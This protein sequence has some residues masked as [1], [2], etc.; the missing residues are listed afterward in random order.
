MWTDSLREEAEPERGSVTAKL[1]LRLLGWR[2]VGQ[3]PE[4]PKFLLIGAPH[5]SLSDYPLTALLLL[6][7]RLKPSWLARKV[8]FSW[9]LRPLA[10]AL[11]AMPPD[12]KDGFVQDMTD[13]FNASDN[14][15]LGLVPEGTSA[16]VPRWKSGFYHIA[17]NSGVPVV[18]GFIDYRTRTLG[19]G[20][21]LVL[22]GKVEHDLKMLQDFYSDKQGRHPERASPVKI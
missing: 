1:V 10:R 14:M 9:P 13:N 20:P 17:N 19:F 11:G 6:S 5:T 15:V 18:P 8:H 16:F 21:K 12:R 4:T 3:L 22:T 2:V 7:V